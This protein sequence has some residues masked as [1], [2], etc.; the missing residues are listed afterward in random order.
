MGRVIFV[1]IV[2]FSLNLFYDTLEEQTIVLGYIMIAFL[3]GVAIGDEAATNDIFERYELTL[4]R[5]D[6]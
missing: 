4:K 5:R 2:I 3:F 6:N 1:L